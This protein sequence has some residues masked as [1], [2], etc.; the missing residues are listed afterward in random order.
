MKF[1]FSSK[2]LETEIG[3]KLIKKAIYKY[4]DCLEDKK[5]F[6]FISPYEFVAERIVTACLNMG[7]AREN[8]YLE[9]PASNVGKMNYI[10]ITS[11]NSWEILAEMRKKQATDYIRRACAE[12][13]EITY[14]GA[15]AGCLLSS[16]TVEEALEF[17]RNYE[18]IEDFSGL[19]L[20]NSLILPHYNRREK[21]RYLEAK[22][23]LFEKYKHIYNVSDEDVLVLDL[24]E[25]V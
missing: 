9:I 11:G 22:P 18:K 12:N 8:I 24:E 3:E 19:G 17:D 4:E 23:E 25:L 6:L 10:Y 7:F 15:S 2:G 21:M 16:F 1:I 14:I 5:I 20:H 13:K